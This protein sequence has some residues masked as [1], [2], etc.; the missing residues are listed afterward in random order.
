MASN[1]P[2][3]PRQKMI[4]LMYLVFIAMLALNVSS[5]VL[6]GF[7]LV[8]EGLQQ[9]IKSTD[10]QN[11]ILL[12]RL[13]EMYKVNPVKT[14]E[15][16][17]KADVFK[18]RSDSLYNHI[19][20]LKQQIA[21]KSDGKNGDPENLDSK[22]NLDAASVVMLSPTTRNGRKLRESIDSFRHYA[23]SLVSGDKKQII[24]ERL[25]T[26]PS[27]KLS[28]D[29]KNW[30]QGLFEQMPAGAAVTLLTKIQS[31]I[32][33]VEGEV[34]TELVSNI[35]AGDYRVNNL[36]AL[37]V[38]RSM[39]VMQGGSYEGEIILSAVDTT[40][41]PRIFIGETIL[42]DSARGLF[43]IP[44]GGIGADKVFSGYV[45]LDRPDRESL[46][47]PF[48]SNYTVVEPMATVAPRLMNV[49]Y[50]GIN[51]EVDISVPGVSNHRIRAQVSGGSGRLESKGNYWIAVPTKVGQDLIISVTADF[52]NGRFVEVAKK[53]FKVRALPDPTPYIEYSDPNGNPQMFKGGRIAKATIVNAAGLK[54][55]IDDGVLNIPF[56]VLRFST[57][58]FDGMGNAVREISSGSNFSEKQN[59]QIRRL[60]RGKSFFISDVKV[61]GPDGVERDIAAMEVRIN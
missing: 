60:T 19:Q 6:N 9:T 28:D 15:W 14:E 20:S 33:A 49:L 22:E 39:V 40:K 8:E 1:N 48:R 29:N 36:E 21:V 13:G 25:N 30:E 58:F 45:E 52:G 23:A 46:K 47:I 18:K 56:T 55:A 27:K 57:V 3:S 4:N 11:G 24:E 44:A 12:D 50:A 26:N 17:N 54:A 5:E 10:E 32:R 35:D 34:L 16:Y 31:D 37:V 42:K 53:Q 59:E 51:N 7:D 38:P 2:N 43:R 41:R 61:K